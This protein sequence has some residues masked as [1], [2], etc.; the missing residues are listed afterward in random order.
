MQDLAWG[1]GLWGALWLLWEQKL[2]VLGVVSCQIWCNNSQ[3][4][5]DHIL[6]GSFETAM[7]VSPLVVWRDRYRRPAGSFPALL[8]H[9]LSFT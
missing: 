9:P 6:A 2:I 1:D 3:L 7:R 4:P 8:W 5:V